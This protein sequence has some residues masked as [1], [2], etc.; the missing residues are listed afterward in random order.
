MSPS[1]P[2]ALCMKEVNQ[3]THFVGE[4]SKAKLVVQI[5]DPAPPLRFTETVVR[6]HGAD[7][8]AEG[9]DSSSASFSSLLCSLYFFSLKTGSWKYFF[10][11]IDQ[12]AQLK[13]LHL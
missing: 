1:P 12:I 11:T 8:S 5:A 13:C 6:P 9:V 3:Y 10:P 2:T 7:R 4:G